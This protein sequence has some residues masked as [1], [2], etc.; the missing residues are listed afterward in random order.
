MFELDSLVPLSVNVYDA[1]GNP[2]NAATVALTITQ[3][4]QTLLTP[5][6]TNPPA[7]TGQYTY[8]FPST[9]PGRHLVKWLTTGPQTAYRDVFDVTEDA[10]PA[11]ISLADCKQ[12]LGMDPTDTSDDQELLAKLAAITRSV[13]RYM[14]TAYAFRTVTELIPEPALPVP[15]QQPKVRLSTLPVLALTSAVTLSPTNV[16]TTTY[17]VV[18]NMTVDA[19]SG[20]VNVFNGPPLAGRTQWVYTAGYQIIPYHIIEGSKVLFQAVWESRRGPGGANGVLGPEEM[21]DFRH[22][23]AFPRKVTE[24]FGP[25]R[26]VIY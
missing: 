13:E 6:V 11:I 10:P 19:E 15:W 17:D 25:P 9:Q 22:F 8:A 4:D 23:T 20:L 14:H 18:N 2:A 21:G 3:P 1:N 7:V 26:P 24:W 12:T 16:V 5:A